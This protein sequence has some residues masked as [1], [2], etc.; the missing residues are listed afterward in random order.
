MRFV[1]LIALILL[2]LTSTLR[3]QE[4]EPLAP[5][6]LN[7]GSTFWTW[8]E[9]DGLQQITEPLPE[10]QS[11]QLSPDRQWIVYQVITP[12]TQA[13]IDQFCPCGGGAFA[14]DFW[15]LNIDTGEQTQ[16]AGQPADADDISDEIVRSNPIWSPDSTQLAWVEGIEV[17]DLTIY[18]LA[19][20]ETR[21]I[22]EG[23]EQLGLSSTVVALQDWTEAGI[24]KLDDVY[25][26]NLEVAAYEWHFF[27][28][29]TGDRTVV[30]IS[31]DNWSL[32]YFL[33]HATADYSG[34]NDRGGVLT[35]Q[36]HNWLLTDLAD[37]TQQ[38]VTDAQINVYA[39]NAPETSL[40]LTPPIST[41][42]ATISRPSKPR[43]ANRSWWWMPSRAS[44][45]RA[46]RCSRL[47]PAAFSPSI[48]QTSLN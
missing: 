21:T 28:P 23:L 11:A 17:G 10:Y 41:T 4:A 14:T 40:R 31:L 25:G 47:I 18:D 35:E 29:E 44:R 1:A 39:A 12:L 19:T 20:G 27:D 32:T 13:Y 46:T 16:I 3:A 36:D 7:D 45:P 24:Y 2:A 48:D 6:Y 26:D 43:T 30:P 5:I 33:S 34:L 38:V 9:A 8:T 42:T 15:L 37:G 22:A